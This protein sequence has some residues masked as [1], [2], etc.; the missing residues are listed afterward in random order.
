MI[1][2]GPVVGPDRGAGRGDPLDLRAT[3]VDDQVEVDG[4]DLRR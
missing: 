4:I 3:V 1:V 2:R